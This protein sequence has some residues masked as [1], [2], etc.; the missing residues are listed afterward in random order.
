[1]LRTHRGDDEMNKASRLAEDGAYEPAASPS[2]W[3][4][5]WREIKRD[6]MALGSLILLG[7]VVVAVYGISLILD[8]KQIVTVDLFALYQPP[9]SKFWL[10]TDYGGRDVFGQLIIGTRNSLSI[11]IIVTVL[12]GIIGILVGLISGYFGGTADNIS[13]RIVDFL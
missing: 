11:G 6:K 3:Q 5:L 12:T 8:Q 7:L 2:S 13:M 9:S 10:G 4:I 1:M